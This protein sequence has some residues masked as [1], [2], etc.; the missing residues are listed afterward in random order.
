[1]TPAPS[2]K[3]RGPY[4]FNEFGIRVTSAVIGAAL[5][6]A[7]GYIALSRSGGSLVTASYD[8]PFV[9]HRA[10]G[11]GDLRIVYLSELDG[12]RLDRRRQA[13]LLDRL[14]LAGAKTV[15]YDVV[16]NEPSADPKV[17]TEFAAAMRRFRGVDADGNPIAGS[18]RRTILLACERTSY[19]VTGA[20]VE[21]L[22][23]PTEKIRDAADDFGLIAVDDDAFQIRKLPTGTLDD[24]SLIWKAAQAAGARLDESERLA[25]RWLNYLGP[26]PDPAKPDSVPAIPSCPD[27]VVLDGA[28]DP[29]FFRDKTVLV[30]G[31][32]GILGAKPGLDIFL[33]PFHRFQVGG[34]LPYMS[35]VEMWANAYSNLTQGNW[36]TK[37][38][39]TF[40]MALVIM[41]GLFLG[42]GFTLTRPLRTVLL[43][44]F[45]LVV[46]AL[47]GTF[48]MHFWNLWFP[49]TVP[50]IA[51]I[52]VAMVWGVGAQFSIER[53]FRIRLT[54][55]QAA[56]REAF[57]KYLSPQMLDRMTRE[58]FN[59]NL[60]GEKVYA[61]VMFTDL[62]D[63][64]AL[65]ERIGDPERIVA[66]LNRY[67]ERAT[68]SIFDDEGI[69]VKFIGDA[70]FA[71]WGTPFP[72]P[73]APRKAIRSAWNLSSGDKLVVDGETL[74]TRVGLHYGEAVAGN[75][76]SS[77]RVDFTLIGDSVNLASRLEGMNKMLGTSI[78]MSASVFEYAD[79]STYRTRRVGKFRVKGRAEPVEVYELLGFAAQSVEPEWITVYHAALEAFE[80]G[81]RTAAQD[82]FANAC[83]LRS[84]GDGPSRF[85]IGYLAENDLPG[86]GVVNLT[87]K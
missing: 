68:G 55:E 51:Q 44:I 29:A 56:M 81:D 30:G 25:P 82:G 54:K 87:E 45:I 71:A 74:H 70:I 85:F 78:L 59:T 27:S 53:F 17:D 20:A 63:F 34:K 28:V 32:P 3:R 21:Q 50:A 40:D 1:M 42:V 57:A 9:A 38:G 10:G 15:I 72:D 46:A 12:N 6:I 18:H 49:W 67:F 47:A 76:G 35:G 64:T 4:R 73:E 14:N 5:T 65:C 19:Q 83:R 52:P 7:A 2:S 60:G 13:E 31:E 16:F 80:D 75:I 86:D 79:T 48:S 33:T 69:I 24:P 26:P 61:A 22:L 84:R 39:H 37:S 41:A 8:L 23:A 11:G 58:G 77:K 43:A 62:E 36:L 66:T